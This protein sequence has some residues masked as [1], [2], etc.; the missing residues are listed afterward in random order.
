MKKIIVLGKVL[1]IIL[2]IHIGVGLRLVRRSF[3]TLRQLS[4]LMLSLGI[5]L[6]WR[7]RTNMWSCLI[8]H[9]L[10]ITNVRCY[11]GV[12]RLDLLRKICMFKLPSVYRLHLKDKVLKLITYFVNTSSVSYPQKNWTF[13]QTNSKTGQSST[14]WMQLSC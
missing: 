7:N 8:G 6:F 5:S 3:R 4:M 2:L 14:S 9:Y 10:V 1:C 12:N 11:L 13:W